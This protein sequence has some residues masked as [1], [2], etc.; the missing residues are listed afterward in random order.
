MVIE[1]KVVNTNCRLLI[2]YHPNKQNYEATLGVLADGDVLVLSRL[3]YH[4][5]H[6]GWHVH[7]CCKDIDKSN[8]GRLKYPDMK[9]VP[10]GKSF[11]RRND[12]GIT[13]DSAIRPAIEFY[14]LEDA[15]K[16][17]SPLGL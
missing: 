7:G 14:R 2:A 12:F 15:L 16:N 1:F 3:E 13:G 4:S 9:R 5:T 10:D 6:P 8:V 17:R 11:H